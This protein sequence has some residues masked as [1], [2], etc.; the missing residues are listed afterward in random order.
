[1]N[2]FRRIA[3]VVQLLLIDAAAVLTLNT[4]RCP[5]MRRFTWF[6]SVAATALLFSL[7]GSRAEAGPVTFSCTAGNACNGATYALG[8]TDVRPLASGAYRYTALFGID[9]TGY[10]GRTTDYVHA[11]SFKNV[12]G[13]MFN[14]QL[15]DAPGGVAAWLGASAAGL[16]AAGCTTGGQLGACASAA[17]FGAAVG[18]AQQLFWTFTFESFRGTPGRWAHIKY[19]YVMDTL[20]R[21]GEFR[22]TGS[23]GSFNV[24]VQQLNNVP[25][26]ASLSLF[27]GGVGA[28]LFRRRRNQNT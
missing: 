8:I 26:P 10:T 7:V 11:V 12:V 20:N 2:G 21:R 13:D 25:E 28:W 5:H 4:D 18:L 17:N 16:N 15:I 1:M 27:G 22:P 9:T 24:P 3:T 6:T 14:L 19:R 23:L